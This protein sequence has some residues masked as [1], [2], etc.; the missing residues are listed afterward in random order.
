MSQINF[1]TAQIIVENAMRKSGYG[2]QLTLGNQTLNLETAWTN[3]SPI[4]YQ[5]LRDSIAKAIVDALT[6]TTVTGTI[7]NGSTTAPGGQIVTPSSSVNLN[8][9]NPAQTPLQGA[10]RLGDSI[11]ITPVS[12][13]VFFT[14]LTAV[15]SETGVSPAPVSITGK[16]SSSSS[17]VSIGG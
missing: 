11:T 13:P 15:A 17:T 7:S 4:N 8:I 14:W 3:S 1:S 6:A 16:I 9:S 2:G 5:T 10:A 12:D